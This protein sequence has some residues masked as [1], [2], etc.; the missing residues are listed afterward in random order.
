MSLLQQDSWQLAWQAAVELAAEALGQMDLEE[1]CAKSGAQWNPEE[2]AVEIPFLNRRY[3]VRPPDFAVSLATGGAEVPLTERILLLHYLQT[4]SGAPLRGEWIGF[5][6]VPG[7]E[8]YLPNFRARSVEGLVRKFAGREN[9]L[10]AAGATLG[11][12]A[13]GLGDVSVELPALPRVPV[14]L[15]LWRGDEEF[16]PSGDLLFDAAVAEYLPVEDM[17]VLAGMTV[18]RLCG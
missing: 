9:A 13:A 15:V 1:Q 7:G 6:Q 10:L 5:A 3:R 11:G 16:A 4:A 2:G 8:F 18:G 12:S 17:V 14:A